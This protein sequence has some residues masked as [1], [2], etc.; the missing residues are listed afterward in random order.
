MTKHNK[1]VINVI[2][3]VILS[4]SCFAQF[5]SPCTLSTSSFSGLVNCQVSRIPDNVTALTRPSQTQL[6]EWKQLVN[7]MLLQTSGSCGAMQA[8]SSLYPFYSLTEFLD[9]TSNIKYCALVE[10][11]YKV[12][13][14][15]NISHLGW[16]ATNKNTS[17]FF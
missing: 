7:S 9:S 16:Y 12:I 10:S 3:L 11:S 17:N 5:Y 2:I 6:S 15:K 4:T 14:G 13:N 8:T 1:I